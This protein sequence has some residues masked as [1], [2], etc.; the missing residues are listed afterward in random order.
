MTHPF[1]ARRSTRC[2]CSPSMPL[3]LGE[4][5]ARHAPTSSA[6][7]LERLRGSRGQADRRIAGRVSAVYG[8]GG[9]GGATVVGWTIGVGTFARPRPIA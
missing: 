3:R 4:H 2:L 1:E 6:A 8:V 7:S 5:R 9:G